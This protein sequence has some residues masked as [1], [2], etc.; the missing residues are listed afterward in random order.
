MKTTKNQKQALPQMPVV[1]VMTGNTYG[2][3]RTYPVND[4]ATLFATLLGRK[5]FTAAELEIMAK[6]G[7]KITWVPNPNI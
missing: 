6:L 1:E 7:F 2:T 3:V 4:N 5:T